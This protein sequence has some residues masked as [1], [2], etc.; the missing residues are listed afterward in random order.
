MPH[1]SPVPRSF[2]PTA[3]TARQRLAIELFAAGL[4]VPEIGRRLGGISDSGVRKLIRR[5][6]DRQAA[7]LRADGA[8]ERAAAQFWQW[9]GQLMTAWMPRALALD[10]KAADFVAKLLALY[11]D[12]KGL[13]RQAG[14]AGSAAKGAIAGGGS[15]ESDHDGGRPAVDQVEV[16]LRLLAVVAERQL[17]PTD[18]IDGDVVSSDEDVLPESDDR[19][20]P[21][22]RAEIGTDK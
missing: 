5:A 8:H 17:P 14:E 21:D 15:G 6:L 9:H 19:S 1:T 11:V 12:V 16:A 18:V 4:K 7:A 22:P 3:V 20:Y 10:D 2:S 13:R